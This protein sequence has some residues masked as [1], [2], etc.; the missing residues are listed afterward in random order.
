MLS[1]IVSSSELYLHLQ[2]PYKVVPSKSTLPIVSNFLF[3]IHDNI[4]KITATD[5]SNTIINQMSL[6]NV[7]GSGSICVE[8]KKIIEILKELGEQPIT[9]N[10]NTETL[11]VEMVTQNGRFAIAGYDPSDYPQVPELSGNVRNFSITKEAL[12]NGIQKTI[13]AVANDPLRPIMNGIYFDIYPDEMCFVATDA[14]KLVRYKRYDVKANFTDSF[15]L[16][17]KSATLLKGML[18][19]DENTISVTF[20]SQ[21]VLFQFSENNYLICRLVDGVY[22][23]YN[24]VIPTNN[25]NKLLVDR[26]ELLNSIKRVNIF[27]NAATNL[28]RLQIT[29]N[30]LIISAQDYNLA[31]SG[32]ESI[33]CS[34][35]GEPMEIG[36]KSI[37]LMDILSN[38]STPNVLIE[39]S[40]PTRAGLVLAVDEDTN[41]E[42]TLM[43]IMPMKINID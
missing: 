21:N 23:N 29:P 2:Q 3:E 27:S 28:V 20:N 11:N 25:P 13:F 31:Q 8:A 42:N 24:S 39:L 16:S 9:F 38:H 1:F 32:T 10:I 6:T 4:L 5:T 22:P 12:L 18:D 35:E 41:I 36:F 26:V 7:E 14:H 34:Y 19:K 43:L 17:Q 33:A 40:D 15:I 30:Q 37:F